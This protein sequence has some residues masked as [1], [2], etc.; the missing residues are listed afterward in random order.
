MM[1]WLPGEVATP[2]GTYLSSLHGLY[3]TH[4][5]VA[6]QCDISTVFVPVHLILNFRNLTKHVCIFIQLV[7]V[8]LFTEQQDRQMFVPF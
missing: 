4:Y 7:W 5:M 8:R 3:V 2:G 1:R 6:I